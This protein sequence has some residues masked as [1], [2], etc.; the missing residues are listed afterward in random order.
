[1][2]Q[3]LLIIS[4]AILATACK[5]TKQTES[6]SQKPAGIYVSQI[7]PIFEMHC[8]SCHGTNG[9]AGFDFTNIADVRRAAATGQ[10]M[11]SIK[12]LDGYK[13]MPMRADKLDD[14]TIMK[15]DNWIKDGMKD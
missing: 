7:H 8:N 11:G 14:A 4:A 1:M 6:A 15:L 13:K 9:R 10:L 5:S 2:K 12:W 3:Y